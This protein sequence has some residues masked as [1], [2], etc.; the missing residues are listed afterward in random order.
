LM[1]LYQIYPIDNGAGS[2]TELHGI[3]EY[4]QGARRIQTVGTIHRVNSD[5]GTL[6]ERLDPP[7]TPGLVPYKFGN[8]HSAAMGLNNIF[9]SQVVGWIQ[10]G[11]N[12]NHLPFLFEYGGNTILNTLGGAAGEARSINDNGDIAG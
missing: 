6:W 10:Q 9:P 1:A 3:G 4:S 12:A 7:Q 2:T 5:E 11:G 8:N